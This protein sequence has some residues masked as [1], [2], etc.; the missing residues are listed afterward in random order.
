MMSS[1]LRE[2][3]SLAGLGGLY[4]YLSSV[5]S[6]GSTLACRKKGHQLAPVAVKTRI[7]STIMDGSGSIEPP[8]A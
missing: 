2:S 4:R 7:T 3:I 8:S 6:D 1:A 5:E